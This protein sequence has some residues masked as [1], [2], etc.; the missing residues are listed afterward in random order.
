MVLGDT[1]LRADDHAGS[2][3]QLNSSPVCVQLGSIALNDPAHPDVMA[4]GWEK[5]TGGLYAYRASKAALNAVTKSL[6][7]DLASKNVTTVTL[8][9]GC[10]PDSLRAQHPASKP[11]ILSYLPVACNLQSWLDCFQWHATLV[12]NLSMHEALSPVHLLRR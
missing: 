12:Q 7:V 9:P 3:I 8:H 10:V 1:P 5:W 6:A 2:H 11:C 4:Q